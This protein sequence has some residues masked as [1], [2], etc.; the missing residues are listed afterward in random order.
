[1]EEWQSRDAESSQTWGEGGRERTKGY[2]H[3]K[4]RV[5]W[6]EVLHPARTADS[7]RHQ[8]RGLA[9]RVN[10]VVG[11]ALEP[12]R[13][14]PPAAC[15]PTRPVEEEEDEEEEEEEEE[16]EEEKTKKKKKKN[17]KKKRK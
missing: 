1:M 2:V 4:A 11:V 8:R 7:A 13:L 10:L 6:P 3:A 12:A 9:R 14:V 15:S 5:A 16:V 17:K